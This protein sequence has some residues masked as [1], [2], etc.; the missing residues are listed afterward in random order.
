MG[1]ARVTAI[2]V[3]AAMVQRRPISPF[4]K[5]GRPPPRDPVV[6]VAP[7]LPGP[8]RGRASGS[9]GG[10]CFI[11]GAWSVGGTLP[12]GPLVYSPLL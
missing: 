7:A 4:Q 5:R 3:M 12:A 9:K 6:A 8:K 1:S 10:G 2:R 11:A